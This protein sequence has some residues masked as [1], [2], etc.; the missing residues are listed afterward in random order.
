M[1]ATADR[2]QFAP[3]A[4]NGHARALVLAVLAH[5]VLVAAL[6]LGVQW[7]RSAPTMSAEAEL[8]SAV[9]KAAAPKLVE[10]P[11]A[12]PPPKPAPAPPPPTSKVAKASDADIALEREKQR[13]EQEKLLAARRLEQET[14]QKERAE[15]VKLEKRKLEQQKLEQLQ[16][17]KDKLA[18]EKK[19]D[20]ELRLAQEKKKREEEAKRRDVE[21][22]RKLALKAEQDKHK[23]IQQA[24][25]EKAESIKLERMRSDNLQRIAGLAGASGAATAT[26]SAQKSSG[27]S[28]SY[29]SRV[30]AIVKPNIVFTEDPADNPTALVEVRVAPDGTIV[31]RKLL[32]TSGNKAWDDAVLKAIDKTA[33]LPRDVDG[34]VPPLLEINFRRRD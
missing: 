29:G 16:R 33:L 15:K 13:L 19:R 12:P 17:D 32:K 6:T 1:N 4:T 28:T 34:T 25:L 5:L 24:Q 27:G 26:G 14:A 31:G 30:S 8:W 7:K 3:P 9:P 10:A 18:L 2:L 20:Q 23:A 11:V 22:K 21:D